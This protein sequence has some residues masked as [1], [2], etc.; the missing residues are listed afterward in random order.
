MTDQVARF[1]IASIALAVLAACSNSDDN[2]SKSNADPAPA[3]INADK[4]APAIMD[5]AR[6]ERGIVQFFADQGTTARSVSCPESISGT[7]GDETTCDVDFSDGR[8]GNATIKI[9]DAKGT[10]NI[11]SFQSKLGAS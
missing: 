7:L 9:D 2:K 6:V 10:V 8:F 1:V 3:T 11:I 5:P 4:N